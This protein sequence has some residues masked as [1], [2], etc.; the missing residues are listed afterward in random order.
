MCIRDSCSACSRRGA[1]R[2]AS[3]GTVHSVTRDVGERLVVVPVV[4]LLR[5]SGV[6]NVVLESVC[7]PAPRP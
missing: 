4:V 1:R 6:G 7:P 5:S 2:N 3:C